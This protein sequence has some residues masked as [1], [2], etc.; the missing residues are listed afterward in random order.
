MVRRGA[1]ST[2]TPTPTPTH[3]HTHTPTHPRT[4][5]PAQAL[6]GHAPRFEGDALIPTSFVRRDGLYTSVFSA[7]AL[8]KLGAAA[9]LVLAESSYGCVHMANRKTGA[10]W[11][12]VMLT[13]TLEKP[14]AGQ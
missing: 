4:S 1:D 8:A 3:P 10:E 13:A 11:D 12:R 9:G 7:A 14:P 6:K 5:S 2:S